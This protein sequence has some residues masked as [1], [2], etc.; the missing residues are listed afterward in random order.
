MN[1]NRILS[2]M[3][4]TEQGS[5]FGLATAGLFTVLALLSLL[6]L[7]GG[8]WS[9]ARLSS[10][11]GSAG[12]RQDLFSPLNELLTAVPQAHLFGYRSPDAAYM[13]I[14]SSQLRLT[15]IIQLGSEEDENAFSKAIISVQGGIGKVFQ[16]GDVVQD[17]VKLTGIQA[18]AAVLDNNGH[19]ERLPLQR[20]RL[21]RN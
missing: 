10:L 8:W 19:S 3:L 13:P 2:F 7:L 17:G 14:T 11:S 12:E 21:E 20:A 18:D 1:L 9:D 15:G 16:V 6:T 5:R 4:T